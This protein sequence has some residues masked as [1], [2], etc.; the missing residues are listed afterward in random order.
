MY[1][2]IFRHLPGPTWFKVIEALV[3]VAA[4]VF[5]LF[6][7]VFPWAQAYFELGASSVA[8]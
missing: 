2:W 5:A 1:G 6:K 4:I 7:W 8:V 3:I